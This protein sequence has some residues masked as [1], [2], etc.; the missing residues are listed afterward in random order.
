MFE[1]YIYIQYRILKTC[2]SGTLAQ[3]GLSIVNFHCKDLYW[4]M[5][6]Y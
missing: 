2:F 5:E 4:P 1:I 3:F 6:I